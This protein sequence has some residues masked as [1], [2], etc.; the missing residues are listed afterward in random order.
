MGVPRSLEPQCNR[1]ATAMQPRC[2]EWS[3]A[4]PE[5]ALPCP[6]CLREWYDAN[7][8]LSLEFAWARQQRG[9]GVP[10]GNYRG[11]VRANRG[12]PVGLVIWGLLF[13]RRAQLAGWT[14]FEDAVAVTVIPC[15][16]CSE[17]SSS[18]SQSEDQTQ[19][20]VFVL[21]SNP[22][23]K[24]P[25]LVTDWQQVLTRG[26]PRRGLLEN[27]EFRGTKAHVDLSEPGG[28]GVGVYRYRVDS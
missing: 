5:R 10:R 13:C 23:W 19:S 22:V 18:Q 2:K 8:L 14:E 25:S 17:A 21:P 1:N 11:V 15:E 12:F 28:H 9:A 20:D 3:L 24:G 6:A 7:R 26:D 4:S 16:G 27:P